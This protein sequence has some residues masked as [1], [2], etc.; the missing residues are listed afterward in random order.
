MKF[1]KLQMTLMKREMDTLS[2]T[3]SH[4]RFEQIDTQLNKI[5]PLESQ[6]ETILV[7]LDTFAHNTDIEYV[8]KKMRNYLRKND[9]DA[10]KEDY[11]D[12]KKSS[13]SIEEI[14]VMREDVTM[15]K[16]QKES[17]ITKNEFVS[18]YTNLI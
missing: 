7:K 16:N 8:I 1:V 17:Y 5:K 9:F 6:I 13:I 2:R 12:F 14:E 15:L 3:C 4:E 18:R 11:S 10:F